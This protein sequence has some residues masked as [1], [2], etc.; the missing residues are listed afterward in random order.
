MLV[1]LDKCTM[2]L[3]HVSCQ[4]CLRRVN[5]VMVVDMN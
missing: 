1:Y 5:L 3:D 4:A 2:A